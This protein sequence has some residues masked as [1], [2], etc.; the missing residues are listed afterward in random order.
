[1]YQVFEKRIF[2]MENTSPIDAQH[3]IVW[4][5]FIMHH[6]FEKKEYLQ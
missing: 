3:N 5:T 2:T 4:R 1:M 6:V